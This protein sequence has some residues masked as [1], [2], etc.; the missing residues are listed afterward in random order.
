M[1]RNKLVIDTVRQFADAVREQG[2]N[3][4]RVVLFG[5]YSRGEERQWS[6][7]DVALVADEFVGV[8]PEDVKKFIDATIQKPFQFI[9][10]HTFNTKDFQED[11][12]FATE[13]MRT[14][15]VIN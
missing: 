9:E 8:R 1:V 2:V 10:F 15:I 7:I 3:L 12:P 14:G 5:S 6:D 11:N 13:I 4:K